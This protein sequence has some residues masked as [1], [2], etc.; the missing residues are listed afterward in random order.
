MV[1]YLASLQSLMVEEMSL[2]GFQSVARSVVETAARAAPILD[3]SID[4]RERVVRSSLVELD[5]ITE[6]K[7]VELA[8]AGDGSHFNERILE[9]RAR[10]ALLGI[11]EKLNSGAGSSGST[12]ER[13]LQ[14]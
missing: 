6:A 13:F 3:P 2:F 8:G 11:D 14:G 5:S 12:V 10:L 4:V 7:K 1:H 9:F